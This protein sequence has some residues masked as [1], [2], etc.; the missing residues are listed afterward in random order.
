M[1]RFNAIQTP[2][3][4]LKRIERSPI[5]DDRGSLSRIFCAQELENAGWLK[6]VAQINHA[7]TNIKG[8]VRGMH[9]QQSP[10]AEAKLVS[11]IRGSIWDVAVDL[12]KGSTT[13]LQW[14]AQELSP[15][16]NLAM[17]IPEGFAHGFQTLENDCE[18]VYVHSAPFSPSAEARINPQDPSLKIRWPLEIKTISTKD[19]QQK[20]IDAH[21]LGVTL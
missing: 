15:Q 13:F 18:I 6:S 10:H 21:F 2:L 14:F 1:Q 8:T 7:R 11:C 5:E 19:S 16:N 4:G 12:R 17:L 20:Y 3:E 9:Y